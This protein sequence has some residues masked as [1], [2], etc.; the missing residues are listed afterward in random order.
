M[1][2]YFETNK[3]LI[4]VFKKTKNNNRNMIS[5]S[6]NHR[7]YNDMMGLLPGWAVTFSTTF[8]FHVFIIEKMNLLQELY[9]K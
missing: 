5:F 1:R 8:H 4:L 9:Y 6:Y 2:I 7:N 3:V